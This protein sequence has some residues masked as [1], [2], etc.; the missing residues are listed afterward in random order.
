[1]CAWRRRA[2]LLSGSAVLALCIACSQEAPAPSALAIHVPQE[3]VPRPIPP[4]PPRAPPRPFN[5]ARSD[6]HHWLD[7]DPKTRPGAA[8]AKGV[9]AGLYRT[10]LRVNAGGIPRG[11]AIVAYRPWLSRRLRSGLSAAALERDRYMAL[12]P[13]DKP[14]FV[15]SDIF[16]GVAEGMTDF[17]VGPQTTIGRNK[18]RV[19]VMLRYQNGA[20]PIQWANH[21]VVTREDGRWV[22]DDIRYDV[23]RG[24]D[25]DSSLLGDLSYSVSATG[26][27]V[28]DAQ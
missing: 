15:D 4:P 27:G 2:E 24:S 28:P 20:D 18:V 23:D 26:D 1:M 12:R 10:H 17:R 3:V 13:D 8:S 14:P 19:V 6:A 7:T 16:S 25:Q 11:D 21:V 9:V 22:V 5:A